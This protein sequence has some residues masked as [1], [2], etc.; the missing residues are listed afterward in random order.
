MYTR[1]HAR[2]A[3]HVGLNVGMNVGMNVGTHIDILHIYVY[4]CIFL[5]YIKIIV[6]TLIITVYS[7][8]EDS[9]MHKSKKNPHNIGNYKIPI[10]KYFIIYI[11]ICIYTYKYTIDIYH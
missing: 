4:L 7:K 8:N 11:Y 2:R 6:N 1:R 5:N 3:L 10:Y 9:N